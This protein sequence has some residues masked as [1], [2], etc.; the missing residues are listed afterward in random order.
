M[1]KKDNVVE[2][3]ILEYILHLIES[4]EGP[5]STNLSTTATC[6]DSMD[7]V[8]QLNSWATN[9]YTLGNQRSIQ[10]KSMLC[11]IF[12][13]IRVEYATQCNS[14]YCTWTKWMSVLSGNTTGEENSLP[15]IEEEKSFFGVSN[16]DIRI[17][18]MCGMCLYIHWRWMLK[19]LWLAWKPAQMKKFL[20]TKMAKLKM[21]LTAGL[22][23]AKE[24]LISGFRK[25]LFLLLEKTN[26]LDKWNPTENVKLIL[27]FHSKSFFVQSSFYNMITSLQNQKIRVM[28]SSKMKLIDGMNYITFWVQRI[29][30]FYHFW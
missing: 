15:G 23:V 6:S 10:V 4:H 24:K 29:L 14:C 2:D 3:S 20:S 19:L 9:T 21:Q 5:F 22:T 16:I 27:S 26:Q 28:F 7:Q 12:H 13:S 18:L 30:L 11:K 25:W 17:R 1:R 8:I